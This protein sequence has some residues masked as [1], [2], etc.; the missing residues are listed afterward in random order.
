MLY[1][2]DLFDSVGITNPNTWEDFRNAARMLKAKGHPTGMQFSRCNDANHNW[3]ALMY[4]FG[5]KETDPSGTQVMI[6]SKETREAMRFAKALYDEG[7][8]PEVFSWDDASDNRF[9]ASGVA[10]WIH[11]AISAFR[12]TEDSNPDV[13]K[14]TYMLPEAIGPGRTNQRLR[15]ERLRDLEVLEEHPRGQGVPHRVVGGPLRR[16]AG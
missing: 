2:K 13:F 14:S 4:C 16:H 11:D 10:S 7:M 8:T 15:S 12:T 6:D 3:R 9:L 5:V 1:R